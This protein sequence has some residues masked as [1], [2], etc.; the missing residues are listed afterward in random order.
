MNNSLSVHLARLESENRDLSTRLESTE[1]KLTNT[2][3]KREQQREHNESMYRKRVNDLESQVRD[4][5]QRM[6]R[7]LSQDFAIKVKEV[8]D[9][10][11]QLKNRLADEF[12]VRTDEMNAKNGELQRKVRELEERNMRHELH[13]CDTR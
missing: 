9:K 12:R 2:N 10:G 6:T 3:S 7:E 13:A 4:I 5:R 8:E 1:Q 11:R